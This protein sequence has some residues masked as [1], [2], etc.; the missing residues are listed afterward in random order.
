[1]PL[2]VRSSASWDR[3][4]G[5][6]QFTVPDEVML[7]PGDSAQFGAADDLSAD[8]GVY[9]SEPGTMPGGRLATCSAIL[10]GRVNHTRP[11]SACVRIC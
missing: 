5:R 9:V 2:A 10:P 7:R 6:D 8:F 4:R 1:M 11:L 3:A